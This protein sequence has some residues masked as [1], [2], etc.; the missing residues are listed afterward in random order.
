MRL[1]LITNTRSTK[2]HLRKPTL[3][4]GIEVSEQ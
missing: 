4:P 1:S 2:A 3:T